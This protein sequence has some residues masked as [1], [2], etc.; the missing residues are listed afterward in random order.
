MCTTLLLLFYL[1]LHSCFVVKFVENFKIPLRLC[2]YFNIGYA[3]LNEQK[4]KLNTPNTQLVFLIRTKRQSHRLG[5]CSTR[6]CAVCCDASIFTEK[7]FLP[8]YIIRIV[9]FIF[10]LI[11]LSVLI[12]QK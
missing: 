2:T 5:C 8:I 12:N 10:E 1:C 3:M 7:L 9:F 11:S 4:L 6:V